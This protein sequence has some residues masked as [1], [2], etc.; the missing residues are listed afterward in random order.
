MPVIETKLNP[1][2]A[3]VLASTQAMQVLV[4]ICASSMRRQRLAAATRHAQ[5]TPRAASC[6]REIA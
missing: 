3:N 4:T 5:S 6:C 1:R 2:D